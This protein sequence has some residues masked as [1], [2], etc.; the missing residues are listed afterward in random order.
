[1]PSIAS[2]MLAKPNHVTLLRNLNAPP[3]HCL[4]FGLLFA[5]QRGKKVGASANSA[6]SLFGRNA[7]RSLAAGA[8]REGRVN[9]VDSRGVGLRRHERETLAS[10]SKRERERKE[11]VGAMSGS[12]GLPTEEKLPVLH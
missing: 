6:V 10:S 5:K 1:M 12:Q 9:R 11:R 8:T 7:R 2:L 4:F 3:L